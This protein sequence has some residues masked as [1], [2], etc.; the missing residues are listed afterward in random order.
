MPCAQPRRSGEVQL[1]I[2]R[3][4]VGKVAPSPRPS[5]ARTTSSMTKLWA[6]P[7]ASVA[8]DQITAQTVSVRRA[9]KRSLIQPPPTC[10]TMYAQAK[11]EKTR[12]IWS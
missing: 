3:V 6:R 10:R 12:P 7:V 4:A 5:S 9:P 1:V 11:A 8:P 2:A